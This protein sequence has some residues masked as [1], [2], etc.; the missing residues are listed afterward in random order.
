LSKCQKRKAIIIFCLKY[1]I[2]ET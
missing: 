2:D 1:V